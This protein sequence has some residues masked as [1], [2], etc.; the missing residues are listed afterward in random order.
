MFSFL[1]M[2]SKTF[3]TSSFEASQREK[4]DVFLTKG[5]SYK[6]VRLTKKTSKNQGNLRFLRL[7]NSELLQRPNENQARH[8]KLLEIHLKPKCQWNSP[9]KSF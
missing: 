6:S 1:K 2:K 8:T 9:T 7:L 4:R 5:R 3:K